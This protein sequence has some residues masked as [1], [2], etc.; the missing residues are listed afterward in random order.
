MSQSR[1]PHNRNRNTYY[2]TDD[3][4]KK[5]EQALK[6]GEDINSKTRLADLC[7]LSPSTIN[8]FFSGKAIEPEN[9]RKICSKL[10]LNWLEIRA[11]ESFDTN[12]N[13]EKKQN[14]CYQEKEGKQIKLKFNVTVDEENQVKFFNELLQLVQRLG[15]DDSIEIIDIEQGSIKL[16]LQ[17][18]PAGLQRLERLFQS[19]ELKQIFERYLNITV[20]DVVF[21]NTSSVDDYLQNKSTTT[22]KT[23][24]AFTIAGDVSQADINVLKA[25]LINT[26]DDKETENEVKLRLIEEIR[27]RGAVGRILS[28]ADLSGA[29]LSYADLSGA[30]LSGADLSNADLSDADLSDANL[31]DA[32]VENA[33]FSNRSLG[34]SESLKRDLIARGAIFNDSP[35]E[36]SEVLSPSNS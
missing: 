35:G 15:D 23:Q 10:D 18:S 9:F 19:G 6:D 11:N 32:N 26:S 24:L 25:A 27:N 30:D 7:E 3:G 20:E 13:E 22:E 31:N 16:T 1:E 17:G 8:N 33:F 29:D 14:S 28:Y 21:L 12:E 5:A 2:A 34:M 4:R 36:R